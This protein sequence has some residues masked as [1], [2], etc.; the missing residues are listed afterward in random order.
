MQAE[1]TQLSSRTLEARGH[2]LNYYEHI[3]FAASAH[4]SPFVVRVVIVRA[5][6]TLTTPIDSHTGT[7]STT[8]TATLTHNRDE[9][10]ITRLWES[11]SQKW[12]SLESVDAIDRHNEPHTSL[13]S[14][15]AA[16]QPRPQLGLGHKHQIQ[17]TDQQLM[18]VA[19]ALLASGQHNGPRL[20]CK[21]A[22]CC[23]SSGRLMAE[24]LFAC[25]LFWR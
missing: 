16:P 21:G 5:T 10:I 6:G 13:V 23:R 17:D 20:G 7:H 11:S 3:V 19:R 1:R 2:K 14:S 12:Q 8:T 22:N 24:L 18:S 25:S 15:A 9:F 4:S